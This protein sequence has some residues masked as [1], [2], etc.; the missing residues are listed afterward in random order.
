MTHEVDLV[1]QLVVIR[2]LLRRHGAD[3]EQAQILT[4]A[5]G[6]RYVHVFED[7]IR[8]LKANLLEEAE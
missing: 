2:Q 6:V 4:D 8:Q 1:D 3:E 5:E 7:G